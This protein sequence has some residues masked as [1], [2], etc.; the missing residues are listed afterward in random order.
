MAN[1]YTHP[2]PV[3]YLGSAG[4]MQIV[5]CSIDTY[6]SGGVAPLWNIDVDYVAVMNPITESQEYIPQWDTTNGLLKL[7]SKATMDEIDAG[8]ITAAVVYLLGFG[9]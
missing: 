5:K 8:T 4:K 9:S 6:A 1:T 2:S 7:F 3:V